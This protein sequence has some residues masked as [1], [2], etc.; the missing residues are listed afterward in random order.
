MLRQTRHP[1]PTGLIAFLRAEL[2]FGLQGL[3]VSDL[4]FS[5]DVLRFILAGVE[6]DLLDSLYSNCGLVF[7]QSGISVFAM[8]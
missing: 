1:F 5:F 4:L 7:N 2:L 8:Q 6:M 3:P